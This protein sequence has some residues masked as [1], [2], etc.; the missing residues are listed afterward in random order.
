MNIIKEGAQ[1]LGLRPCYLRWLDSHPTQNPP[2][3]LLKSLAINS[4]VFTFTLN[5]VLK[6]RFV[7]HVQ[8]WMLYNVY[9]PPTEARWKQLLGGI[10]AGIIMFPAACFG[11][12]LRAFLAVTGKMPE[13]FQKFIDS[14]TN[15][16][17]KEDVQQ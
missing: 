11:A 3:P 9:V 16:C 5:I 4:M 15:E 8:Y 17:G 13:R 6:I 12:I 10:L 14:L 1:E 7:S 2:G